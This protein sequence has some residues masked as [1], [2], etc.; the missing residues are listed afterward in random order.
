MRA[1]QFA[2][3]LCRRLAH[4]ESGPTAVEYAVLLGL[5]VLVAAASIRAVGESVH[6]IW[7]VIH[8]AVT[9]L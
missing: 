7:Q 6:G 1:L 2:A 4:D 3:R 9:E 5:I 8:T